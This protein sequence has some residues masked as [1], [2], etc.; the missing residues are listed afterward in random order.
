[1]TV[2]LAFAEFP[3]TCLAFSDSG[4]LTA[5]YADEKGTPKIDALNETQ[6]IGLCAHHAHYFKE[7]SKGGLVADFSPG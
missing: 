5:I 6:L 1:M 3:D 7:T 2:A 4:M